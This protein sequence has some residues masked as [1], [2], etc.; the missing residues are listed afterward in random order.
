MAG[1]RSA[2]K[3]PLLL[4]LLL[5]AAAAHLLTCPYTKVEE[6]FNLQATHDLLFHRLDVDKFDHHEFP[7]VVPRTFVGPLLLA[8][9]SSPAVCVLSLLEVSKFYSQLVGK[10]PSW[11]E[12]RTEVAAGCVCPTC[13]GVCVQPR[14]REGAE[15]AG[16]GT[17]GASHLA[18]GTDRSKPPTGPA[19]RCRGLALPG[20]VTTALRVQILPGPPP[21][22]GPLAWT[23]TSPRRA[24]AGACGAVSVLAS[25]DSTA[26]RPQAAS[27]FPRLTLRPAAGSFRKPR[28]GS[29]VR[30]GPAPV[31]LCSREAMGRLGA[32]Q[33]QPLQGLESR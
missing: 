20:A 21:S 15:E 32:G 9:L 27:R 10:G 16:R 14:V 13:S 6:S 30:A 28:R 19:P 17:Q 22:P 29:N 33:S 12:R 4:G 25:R 5:S 26:S 1:K 11:P 7:G 24:A 3:Q 2:G 31:H 18:R 23:E 8:A